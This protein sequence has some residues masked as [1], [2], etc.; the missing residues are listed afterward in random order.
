MKFNKALRS[1]LFNCGL[2]NNIHFKDTYTPRLAGESVEA[3]QQRLF[4]RS[5]QWLINHL[6]GIATVKVIVHSAIPSLPEANQVL[7]YFLHQSFVILMISSA[8]FAQN[9]M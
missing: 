7:V 5:V 8:L 9:L 6:Q 2:F 3:L 4:L 1:G